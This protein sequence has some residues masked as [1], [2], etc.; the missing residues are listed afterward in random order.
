MTAEHKQALAEGRSQGN[1]IRRYLEA[2]DTEASK[3]RRGRQRT[4]EAIEKRLIDIDNELGTANALQR[5]QLFQERISLQDELARLTNVEVV[6]LSGLEKDFVAHAK[7]YGERK[8][9]TF[10]AWRQA[11]VPVD[12]LRAA[13]VPR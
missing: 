10:A 5:V 13:G 11:G 2:L 1:A 9:I 6:D 7:P 12:V 8:G 4:P 3:R